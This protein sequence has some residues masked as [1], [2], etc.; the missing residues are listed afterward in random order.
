MA[1]TQSAWP[2][3]WIYSPLQDAGFVLPRLPSQS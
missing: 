2:N 1:T 3:Y